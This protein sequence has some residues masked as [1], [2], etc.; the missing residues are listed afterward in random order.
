MARMADAVEEGATSRHEFDA[1]VL[2][3]V[4][5]DDREIYKTFKSQFMIF[6]LTD[7]DKE[8]RW[9]C[10]ELDRQVSLDAG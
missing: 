1:I 3:M 10:A 7:E 6:F 8:S 5:T 4:V 2:P 9:C